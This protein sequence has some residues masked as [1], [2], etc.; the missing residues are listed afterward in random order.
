MVFCPCT[1]HF[2]VLNLSDVIVRHVCPCFYCWFNNIICIF[3]VVH[4]NFDHVAV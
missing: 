3:S 2:L 4:V 1:A